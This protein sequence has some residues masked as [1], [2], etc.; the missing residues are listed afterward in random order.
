M[1]SART[2]E[3]DRIVDA[4]TELALTPL[5]SASL[6]TLEPSSEPKIVVAALAAT[7]E[8]VKFQIGRAHV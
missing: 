5:G 2:L 1:Q 8:T 7:T 3:F 4:V 6:A